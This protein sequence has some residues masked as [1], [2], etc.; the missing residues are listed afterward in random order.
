LSS[1]SDFGVLAGAAINAVKINELRSQQ[2]GNRTFWLKRRRGVSRVIINFANLFFR[3][4]HNPVF[5][6]GDL[7][8]WRA[9]EIESFLLLHGERYQAFSDRPDQVLV[10]ELPGVN[11]DKLALERQLSAKM[12]RAAGTEF[13]RVHNLQSREFQSGW[14]HGDPNMGNVIYDVLSGRARL[15]DFETAHLPNLDVQERHAD[16]LA[17]FLLDLLGSTTD[18]EWPELAEAFISEYPTVAVRRILREKLVLPSGVARLWWA[19]RTEY[20]PDV[21]LNERLRS[22][23]EILR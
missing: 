14:S 4:A 9:R 5:V 2:R 1:K 22:L 16:D 13:F 3:L 19:I 6:S 17:V 11:L 20:L 15:I 7:D 21:V 18:E 12:I 8:T 10:E 23:S